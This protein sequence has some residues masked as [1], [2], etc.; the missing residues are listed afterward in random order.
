M[1]NIDGQFIY[2][3]YLALNPQEKDVVRKA[4]SNSSHD[5]SVKVKC[6]GIQKYAAGIFS[7]AY[8]YAQK[9]EN[10]LTINIEQIPPVLQEVCYEHRK[11]TDVFLKTIFKISSNCENLN[12]IPFQLKLS[13]DA[14]NKYLNPKPICTDEKD[15]HEKL[16][17]SYFESL[18]KNH[19]LSDFTI[20][21]EDEKYPVHKVIL[22]QCP[23]FHDMFKGISDEKLLQIK[24]QSKQTV[25]NFLHYL[26]K[27]DV[28]EG[29]FKDVKNCLAMFR[30]ADEKEYKPLKEL[31]KKHIYDHIND[32]C[33]IDVAL[34]H[35]EA[36]DEDLGTLCQW[37]V[38]ANPDFG[39]KSDLSTYDMMTLQ[40]IHVIGKKFKLASLIKVTEQMII[41]KLALNDDFI[42]LC[43]IICVSNDKD[44]KNVVIEAVKSK[45]FV[46][47]MEEGKK[48]GYKDLRKAY[49]KLFTTPGLL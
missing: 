31:A 37:F 38:R 20:E 22:S 28:S 48:G 44:L 45:K 9:G 30:F 14:D 4:V 34:L 13:W 17:T 12:K 46:E 7:L 23:S 24:N 18:F 29:Y 10:E 15:L 21:V 3:Q 42:N 32:G 8:P 11:L 2:D 47:T 36:P 35:S 25:Y 41:E 1:N 6:D 16:R 43:K 40:K 33:F 5:P 39:A 19:E 49:L 26:Y 27:Q